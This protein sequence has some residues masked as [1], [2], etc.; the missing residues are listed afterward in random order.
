M[1]GSPDAGRLIRRVIG[2]PVSGGRVSA[3]LPLVLERYNVLFDSIAL[4]PL[5]VPILLIHTGGK[6][7]AYRAG[8]QRRPGQSIPG[9]VT[10][11]PRL[12]RSQVALRGVGEGTIIYFA[13]AAKLPAWLLRS[14]YTS[15]VSFSNEV[16]VSI[17]R[18]LMHELEQGL[19]GT[20]YLKALANALLAEL[21]R[22][23]ARRETPLGV[24]ASRSELRVAHAALEYMLSHLGEPVS[25]A[26][27]ARCCGVGVS[28]FSG[29]F[30]Q[31]TGVTPH[32]YLR[33]LRIERACELLR[34]TGL[35]VGEVAEAVGF[36]GQAH[37]STAFLAERGLTPTAYR[38]ASRQPLRRD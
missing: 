34:T 31:A 37:F 38:R 20:S 11:L 5:P 19:D 8:G 3:R 29:S 33:R 15:P 18:R 24:A 25:V 7:V 16:I 17:T 21:Q 30:R 28:S 36:R 9:L 35:S 4:P 32:R 22:E 26:D 12:V 13:D 2:N 14:R 10:F 23:L 27:L 1:A 6:P